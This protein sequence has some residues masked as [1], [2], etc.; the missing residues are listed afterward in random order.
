MSFNDRSNKL[1]TYVTKDKSISVGDIVTIPTGNKFVADSKI[2]QVAEVFDASL[3]E[4]EF[5]IEA[6]RCVERKLQPNNN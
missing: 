4:L 5:P 3:D 6:L 1:Y 2:L